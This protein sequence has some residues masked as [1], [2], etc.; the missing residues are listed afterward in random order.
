M[1]FIEPL[2]LETWII[3]VFS[4]SSA[5]FLAV[6]LIAIMGLAGLFKMNAIVLFYMIGVFL[7]FFNGWIDPSIFFL[8]LAMGGM[9]IIFWIKSVV[10]K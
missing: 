6:A 1:A 10:S 7:I 2:Q 9:L 5:I 3:N 4:G 8:L